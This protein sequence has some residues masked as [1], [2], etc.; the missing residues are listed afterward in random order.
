MATKQVLRKLQSEGVDW[1][2]TIQDRQGPLA[3]F[4]SKWWSYGFLNR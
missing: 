4:Y 2:G 1:T 3:S